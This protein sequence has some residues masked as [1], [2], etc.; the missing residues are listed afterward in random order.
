MKKSDFVEHLEN[1]NSAVYYS[2]LKMAYHAMDAAVNLRKG[3]VKTYR[4]I[5][6]AFDKID[7]AWP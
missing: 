6:K 3:A 4:V 7:E 5:D 1:S 2:F